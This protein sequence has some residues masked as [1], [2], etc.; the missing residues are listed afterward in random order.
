MTTRKRLL[1]LFCGGGGAGMGYHR[2]GFE[3]VG[4]DIKPQKHYPFAFVLMDAIQA[5]DTLLTG[6]YIT[7]NAGRHWYLDDFD[8][9]HTSPPCQKYARTKNLK[10]S[11]RD[12]PDLIA[13]IREL[14]KATDKPYIIEN[15]AEA[16]LVNA[17]M[18]CGTMFDLG[19]IRHRLFECNPVVWWPPSPCQ[20]E[21][22]IIPMWWKSRQRALLAGGNYKYVHVVGKSFLMPE[23]KAAMG[24]DWMVRD[25]ISQAIPPAYTEWIGQQLMKSLGWSD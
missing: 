20:H 23:A 18:L 12:H 19:V 10:T 13:P 5:L 4:V 8:A 7:D 6:G 16:P 1:D 21:G 25:E 11:R 9:I 3:V 24:I 14:L 22:K 17:I 15:V 2:A